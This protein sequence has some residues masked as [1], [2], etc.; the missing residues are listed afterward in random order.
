MAVLYNMKKNR[1]LCRLIKWI[2]LVII[3]SIS[4]GYFQYRIS[5]HK[6]APEYLDQ[7]LVALT[8][9]GSMDDVILDTVTNYTF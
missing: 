2:S 9:R 6:E 5:I 7:F 4:G 8:D 1:R 3:V